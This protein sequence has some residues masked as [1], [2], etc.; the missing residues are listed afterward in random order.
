[1]Q[2]QRNRLIDM[3]GQRVGKLLVL[4]R[5]PN[6]QKQAAWWCQCGCGKQCVVVGTKLRCAGVRSCGCLRVGHFTHGG[7][8]DPEYRIWASIKRRC[9][10]E[11]DHSWP[12]YGGRGISMHPEWAASYPAFIAAV[13]RRPRAGYELDRYRNNEGYVPGN[14]R[15]VTPSVN[16]SNRRSSNYKH[17]MR[18]HELNTAGSLQWI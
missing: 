9:F 13:G 14:M 18:W 5:G 15:W 6:V 3:S 11:N 17:S 10:N 16:C 1:M 4:R 12:A 8:N 2:S 7:S